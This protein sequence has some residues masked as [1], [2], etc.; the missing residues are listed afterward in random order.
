MD[1]EINQY[2]DDEH[3]PTKEL[4][5]EEYD[6]IVDP[7]KD[8]ITKAKEKDDVTLEEIRALVDT[9]PMRGIF[10]KDYP[11]LNLDMKAGS[12][13][14]YDK[15]R[16]AKEKKEKT[17]GSGDLNFDA[18]CDDMGSDDPNL[19]N[20]TTWEE[21]DNLSEAEKKLIDK[22]VDT[23]LKHAADMTQ[24]K[25]GTIPGELEAYLLSLE[26][27]EKAKF[28]WKGYIRRFTGV[29]TK[30]YTKKV[31]RKENKRFS[32]NPGLKLKMKQHMLLAIDTSGSV[33]DEELKEFMNEIHHIYKTGVD[34]TIIQCDAA[35]QSIKEY[36]GKFDG[37]HIGGRGGTAFDPVLEYYNGHLKKYTSLVYF[38]DG[39]CNTYVK[40][41]SPVLWVLSER[42]HMN[43]DLPGKTI[44]LEL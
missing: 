1:M 23:L 9:I 18:L 41:K 10:I 12:R 27:I 39:E 29:S 4:S 22:Q 14:Y 13:Y 32:D 35:I 44:K 30:V 36:K 24:K 33:S 8:K 38:T 15:L 34:I 19:W 25:R 3:L 28:D 11:D 2:I 5:K 31:R 37:I 42:S 21:F 16:E 7:I 6:A 40:P 17:G 20:H 43:E 26:Q